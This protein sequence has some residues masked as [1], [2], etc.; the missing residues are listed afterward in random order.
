MLSHILHLAFQFQRQHG[1]WPNSLHLNPDHFGHW[2]IECSE[3][4]IFEE[5]MQRLPMIIVISE[6]AQQPHVAW[7]NSPH[8]KRVTSGFPT[9]RHAH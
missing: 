7:V 3:A 8:S 6:A 2:K 4:S 9:V 5:I 1:H